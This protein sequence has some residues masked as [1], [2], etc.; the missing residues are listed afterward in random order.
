MKKNLLL[1][2]GITYIL[3]AASCTDQKKIAVSSPL[4]QNSALA[5][6]VVTTRTFGRAFNF[7]IVSDWGWNGMKHQ[8]EVADQMAKTADSVNAKFIASCGDNFQI[9]GVASAQDPLW[10]NSY[11]NV[12][13]G[14]SL[15]VD[16]Y[17]VLGNHDYKGNP[18]A[19]IDYTKISR[20]WHM[21]DRYYSIRKKINDSVSARLIFLDTPPLI[22]EYRNHPDEYP[23]AVKQDKAKELKWLEDVLASSKEQWKIVFGHHP[24]YSAS[25]KHGNTPEMIAM[26][27]PLLEK[28]NAQF[29]FCGHDH[30]FQ[31][32]HEKGK[33]VEYIVTGTGGE[34]RPAATNEL[35]VFSDSEPGF[36]VI[37]FKSDSLKL[38]FVGTK[39]NII[40]TFTRSYK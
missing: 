39:G 23:D 2:T 37:S 26:V 14:L 25:Q 11:E 34:P 18:Q 12:Y 22:D 21:P 16:W 6:D 35:S 4:I 7:I 15:M 29:Y 20:R 40:Y 8:Q 19:E 1:L 33:N 5:E 3:L 10:T 27:K 24:V 28:Y 13:K 32:L 31:H 9:S 17:P 38:A 30:D 36:S